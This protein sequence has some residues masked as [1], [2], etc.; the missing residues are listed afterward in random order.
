[1]L[2]QTA[3][4]NRVAELYSALENL[5]ENAAVITPPGGLRSGLRRPR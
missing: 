1:M 3:L 4:E 2:Y 5:L